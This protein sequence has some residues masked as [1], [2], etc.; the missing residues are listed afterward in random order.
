MSES[1]TVR[2][3]RSD[4]DRLAKQLFAKLNRATQELCATDTSEMT[5]AEVAV[6]TGDVIR[7]A[8]KLASAFPDG[9]SPAP[10]PRTEKP[11]KTAPTP[12]PAPAKPTP[13]R[14][15]DA[16]PQTASPCKPE[17]RPLTDAA[18]SNRSMILESP[19]NPTERLIFRSATDY[20]PSSK[21][22]AVADRI[23]GPAS[24]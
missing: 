7:I 1:S 10:K 2:D 19:G 21:A 18:R 20:L 9:E 8:K 24:Q 14:T 4:S 15:S 16:N 12:K 6:W 11:V 3:L 17:P 13:N 22:A 23:L 5:T